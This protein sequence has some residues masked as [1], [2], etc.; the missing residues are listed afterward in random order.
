MVA[1]ALV[2]PSL[3]FYVPVERAAVEWETTM[4]VSELHIVSEVP[5]GAELK[6][7]T[8]DELAKRLGLEPG[9]TALLERSLEDTIKTMTVGDV[10]A[11][12]TLNNVSVAYLPDEEEEDDG[13]QKEKDAKVGKSTDV[14]LSFVVTK[15]DPDQRKVFGWASVCAFDGKTVVDKQDDIIR[16]QDLEGAAH[17][18]CLYS[19]TQGD[20]HTDIGVGRLIESMVF[21]ADKRAAGVIAKDDK[22]RV[23]DG[24]WV[25]FLVDDEGVWGA[26]KRGERLEFSIGGRAQREAV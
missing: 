16:I 6:E 15:A 2:P 26:H 11:T 13:K 24:W 22:G 18:F 21:D 1:A 5:A 8:L 19:R 20:M 25:G 17:D 10:H 7:I 23:I 14:R 9:E 12:T 4:G 3:V